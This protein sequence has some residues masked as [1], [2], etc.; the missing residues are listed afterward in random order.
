MND[1]SIFW[2]LAASAT[3]PGCFQWPL[4]PGWGSP[5]LSPVFNLGFFFLALGM[6]KNKKTHGILVFFVDEFRMCFGNIIRTI[7]F[8]TQRNSAGLFVGIFRKLGPSHGEVSRYKAVL[9]VRPPLKHGLKKTW[10][11]SMQRE[12]WW[13]VQPWLWIRFTQVTHVFQQYQG[14]THYAMDWA[15]TQWIKKLDFQA[16]PPIS[17]NQDG[18][19]LTHL[20]S[21][22]GV[23]WTGLQ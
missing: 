21:K 2:G 7:V 16:T 6:T 1:F 8:N 10:P 9:R 22:W 3:L 14:H 4:P 23:G 13:P 19:N 20:S 12:K 15:K 18:A 17:K 11:C 5:H